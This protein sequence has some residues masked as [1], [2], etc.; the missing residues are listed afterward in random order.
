MDEAFKDIRTVLQRSMA[1]AVKQKEKRER[2]RIR[3]LYTP[4]GGK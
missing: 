2:E 4:K 3:R 1:M